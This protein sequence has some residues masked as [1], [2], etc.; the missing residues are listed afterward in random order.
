M[1]TTAVRYLE[2]LIHRFYDGLLL[3]KEFEGLDDDEFET[4]YALGYNYFTY[5]KYEAAKDIFTGLTAYAPY[6]ASYWRAL[7][8][9]KQQLKDYAQAIA[10]YDMAIANDEEDIVSYIYRGESHI[11][12]GNVESGLEN[13]ERVLKIERE[14]QIPEFEPWVKRSK[15]LLSVHKRS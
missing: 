3:L 13:F 14:H 9:V 4:V 6:T 11:L 5:G 12:S 15:L 7:G 8:A 10:A 1:D 2:Y